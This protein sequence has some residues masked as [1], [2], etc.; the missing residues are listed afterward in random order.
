MAAMFSC[1]DAYLSNNGVE[2]QEPKK[3]KK[4][5]SAMETQHGI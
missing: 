4:H 5:N 2:K 1:A 3:G